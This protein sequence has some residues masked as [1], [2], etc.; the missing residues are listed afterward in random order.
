M[1]DLPPGGPGSMD[2]SG[3]DQIAAHQAHKHAHPIEHAVEHA[4]VGAGV[5]FLLRHGMRRHPVLTAWTVLLTIL[6]F[7]AFV[8]YAINFN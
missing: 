1:N 6:A 3:F 7:I 4:A 2:H 5:F 8:I